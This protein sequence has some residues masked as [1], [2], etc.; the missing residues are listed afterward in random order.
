MWV[1]GCLDGNCVLY[2]SACLFCSEEFVMVSADEVPSREDAERQVEQARKEREV[3]SLTHQHTQHIHILCVVSAFLHSCCP[4]TQEREK[5]AAEA[6]EE[7]KIEP[8]KVLL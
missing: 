3:R 1:E 4:F 2:D 6:V 8:A 7:K 5:A